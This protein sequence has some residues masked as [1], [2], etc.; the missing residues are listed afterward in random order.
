MGGFVFYIFHAEQETKRT[1][2]SGV[3]IS[4]TLL[5]LHEVV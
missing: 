5:G 3:A 1:V 2:H 4:E